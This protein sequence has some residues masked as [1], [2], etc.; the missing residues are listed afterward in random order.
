MYGTSANNLISC[1][2]IYI[3]MKG[4]RFTNFTNNQQSTIS[5]FVIN[6]YQRD[7]YHIVINELNA[8]YF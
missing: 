2:N 1:H 7:D 4:F 3:S 8:G 6:S 5:L